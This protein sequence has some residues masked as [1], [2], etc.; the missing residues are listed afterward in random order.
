[1]GH[2]V[3]DQPRRL[4]SGPKRELREHLAVVEGERDGSKSAFEEKRN[5]PGLPDAE[6]RDK[7]R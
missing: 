6:P 3:E 7:Y 2:R 5:K 4:G 1:M